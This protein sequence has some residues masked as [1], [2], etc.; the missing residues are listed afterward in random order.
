MCGTWSSRAAACWAGSAAKSW[1]PWRCV[2]PRR[3]KPWSHCARRPRSR[4]RL[5]PEQRLWFCLS[6]PS[7][8]PPAQ[9][10]RLLNSHL[11][12]CSSNSRSPHYSPR[13]Q[14]GPLLPWQL[15]SEPSTE[16]EGPWSLQKGLSKE[17]K[18]S[19]LCS[20]ETISFFIA[21]IRSGQYWKFGH[22]SS[23]N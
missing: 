14:L 22:R 8:H 20:L 4:C 9:A 17:K 19:K 18:K 5:T 12:L 6:L 7:Q 13:W 23:T 1:S 2:S 15:P 16:M 21:F 11:L 10:F 3:P